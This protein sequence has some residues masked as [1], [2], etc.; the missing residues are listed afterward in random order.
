VN[1][2]D[3]TSL[4]NFARAMAKM[5]DEIDALKKALAEAINLPKGVVPE[6]ATDLITDD[7]IHAAFNRR[8]S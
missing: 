3:D 7:E 8:R 5:Q 4:D 1:Y 2:E 6:S